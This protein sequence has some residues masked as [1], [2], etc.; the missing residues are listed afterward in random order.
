VNLNAQEFHQLAELICYDL[1]LDFIELIAAL[2]QYEKTKSTQDIFLDTILEHSRFM[3]LFERYFVQYGIPFLLDFFDELEK[4]IEGLDVEL[5]ET[6][7]KERVLQLLKPR[8]FEIGQYEQ[9]ISRALESSVA[10]MDGK[11]IFKYEL[12]LYLLE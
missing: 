8:N 10:K 4:A 2:I 3:Y 9:A 11:S 5:I 12:F 1:P 6:G 7:D